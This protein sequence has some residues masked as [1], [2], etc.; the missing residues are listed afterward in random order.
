MNF[1]WSAVACLRHAAAFTL[2]RLLKMKAGQQA[3][4]RVPR[5]KA[6]KIVK[7]CLSSLN[8]IFTQFSVAFYA[9]SNLLEVLYEKANS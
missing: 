3:F 7:K 5:F 2:L 9:A 1:R 8:F 4:G 6:P